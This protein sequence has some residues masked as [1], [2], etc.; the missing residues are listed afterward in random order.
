MEGYAA[1]LGDHRQNSEPALSL[2][3]GAVPKEVREPGRRTPP[4]TFVNLALDINS[5]LTFKTSPGGTCR[6]QIL[7]ADSRICTALRNSAYCCEQPW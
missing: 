1:C 7:A 4:G 3:P 5:Y 6:V 2:C